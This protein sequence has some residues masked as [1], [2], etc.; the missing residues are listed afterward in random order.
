[1]TDSEKEQAL[2]VSTG[3]DTLNAKGT[4]TEH[5]L[6]FRAAD[7]STLTEALEYAARGSTGTNFYDGTGE[8]YASLTYGRLQEDAIDLARRLRGLGLERGARVALVA[9]TDP[10]FLRYFFACQYAGLVPVALPASIH[11]GGRE[12]Y[13]GRARRLIADCAASVVIAPEDFLEFIQEATTGRALR[14]VGSP[15]QLEAKGAPSGALEPLRATEPAYI[16]Y[17]SGSTRF[18]RGV[19]TTQRAVLDN[20][21]GI[22]RHGIRGR[23][24]DR[25]LSWLPFYHD[26]GLV[27]LVLCP[28]SAQWSVDYFDPR[29]FALRPR[30]WP[31]LMSRTGA[32]ISFSPPFGYELCLRRLRD[33]DAEQYDL[34]AWRVA[35]VGAEM[36][37]RETLD[38]FAR[39]LAPSG[40]DA[41]AFLPCYGMAECSLAVSFAP[42]GRGVEVHQMQS[43]PTEGAMSRP[44][45]NHFVKCGVALPGHEISIRDARGRPLPEERIGRIWVRGP[46]IMSGYFRQPQTTAEILSPDGWL[47][48]GDLGYRVDGQLV[49]TGRQ[50]DLIIV[51]GR[52]IWPQDLEYLAEQ[53]SEV[54]TMGASAFA[55][56]GPADTEQAVLVVESR[57]LDMERRTAL[58]QRLRR[59]VLEEFGVDCLVELVP[60]RTLPR[61]SS[62]KLSRS[63]ARS[64]YLQRT[65][66]AAEASAMRNAAAG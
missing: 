41:G 20:L 59:L 29:H 28:V 52:N 10:D 60:P 19:V 47:D 34:R 1:M 49:V 11:L 54:R 25:G 6:P 46:S 2:R 66:A 24:A 22:L 5:A 33:G 40:F 23:S 44:H 63:S 3:E 26:M 38:E 48:T 50:K 32:T 14:F 15:R 62:G 45:A 13:V 39:A 43:E 27:G 57:L 42:L 56:T 16:Q 64:E 31:M 9:S 8:L 7:F 12:A 53:Q 30:L 17:T 36:I 18:P 61:T 55:V 4:P 51:N 58:A 35:G 21:R 37:R 65:R